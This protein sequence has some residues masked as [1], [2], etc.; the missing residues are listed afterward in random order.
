[1]KNQT[2]EE[3]GKLKKVKPVFKTIFPLLAK[4]YPGYFVNEV[5]NIIF[6][7]INPFI[8][9]TITPLLI[10]ELCTQRN[11]KT[12]ITYVLLLIGLETVCWFFTS[13]CHHKRLK[14]NERINNYLER[15]LSRHTMKLDFQLTEDKNA[16]D[17]L[18]KARNGLSWNGNI[19][20]ILTNFFTIV[21]SIIRTV[22]LVGIICF[23]APIILIF[24][25]IDVFASLF[26]IEKRNQIQFKSYG[27]LSKVHR[28]MGYFSWTVTQF[29]FGKDIR[30]YDS[31][32]MINDK[33]E[34]FSNESIF[35]YENQQKSSLKY[36]IAQSVI[37]TFRSFFSFLYIGFLAING[38]LTIGGFTKLIQS[39]D[40]LEN[41]FSNII[42]PLQT[43]I[44]KCEYFYEYVKFL[45][46]PQAIV[47]GN[48]PIE[49][50]P[51]TIEF[52]NLTFSYPGADKKVLDHI[53]L[54]IKP[55][56][57]LSI[58]GL[59]GAGKTTL[60]KLLCRLYDVT[61]GEILVDGIN[62]KDYDYEQYMK[63]F[64]PVFQDFQMF[65]FTI[66]ENIT[67]KDTENMSLEEKEELNKIINKVEL[68]KFV[69]KQEN[70]VKT[71][72]FRHFD[73]EGI[74]PSGGEQ[75]KLAIARALAKNAPV[76]ILD[77][78]TAA[79]DPIAEYEIYKQFNT[80]VQNNT[81]FYISHR[82]S[83]CKF[84]DHIVV[85]NEG[86]I[87]EYGTHSELVHKKDGIYSKMFEAQAEYYR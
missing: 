61:D 21:S 65:G 64:A 15:R 13:F 46:Y 18:E 31:K 66:C 26:F 45:N 72:L 58:V 78:P 53:N 84:C 87:A 59:N 17:Q 39:S 77:E 33:W 42:W 57:K 67:F 68:D 47:K 1:M 23:T 20:E 75:Q 14:Y 49:N 80:L 25:V 43:I 2:T 48:I 41:A 40:A 79:L 30:L 51:H 73:E 76:I 62:I 34:K 74:E 37:N 22:G 38:K 63:Q 3:K 10:D 81:T 32:D 28:M 35:H 56:E 27:L 6:S 7:S 82:L 12:I 5:V 60:I 52:K 70:G 71:Y 36:G 11:I 9:I 54:T 83:S 44:Q 16:L 85:I 4:K 50:N 24:V 29:N 8:A 55:G 19:T 86:K 69:S